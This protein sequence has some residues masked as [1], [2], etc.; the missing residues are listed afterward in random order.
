VYIHLNP[1]RVQALGLGKEDREREKAGLMPEEPTGEQVKARLAKL[2]G[3]CWSSYPAYAGY[4]PKPE[5]L[6]C[7]RLWRRA[8]TGKG[9][10]GKA[11]YRRYLEDY[12][13]QG[14]AEGAFERITAAVAIGGAAFVERLRRKV[15]ASARN[16]TNARAWRR[17]LPFGE[18]V[19]AVET[20]KG[21]Q[22]ESFAGRKG[23][24]GR[25]LALY[26]ARMNCGLSIPELAAHAG[27]GP[28]AASK[29]IQRMRSRLPGDRKLRSMSRKVSVEIGVR[30]T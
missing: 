2:R 13:R 24:C 28:A 25:D 30:V 9:G 29:A 3:H 17:L 27:L 19:K 18:V 4:A 6:T 1:V 5:W 7:E 21:E 11:G 20:V 16:D 23:D 14:V 10:D 22:W 26:V 8:G 12:L 15:P